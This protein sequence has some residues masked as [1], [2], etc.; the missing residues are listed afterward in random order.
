MNFLS[1]SST[2]HTRH[3]NERG[4]ELE[5]N[6]LEQWSKDF[7]VLSGCFSIIVDLLDFVSVYSGLEP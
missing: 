7:K 3:S 6:A 2:S 5:I 4:D 1:V